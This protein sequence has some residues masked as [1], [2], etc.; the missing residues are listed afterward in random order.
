MFCVVDCRRKFRKSDSTTSTDGVNVY[1]SESS[2][3]FARLLHQS[4]KSLCLLSQRNGKPRQAEERLGG[5][6]VLQPERTAEA[7]RAL[8]SVCGSE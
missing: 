6:R 5:T 3:A 4:F 2:E 1:L 8:D 7:E